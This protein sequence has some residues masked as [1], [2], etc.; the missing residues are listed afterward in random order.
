MVP[1]G[2]LLSNFTKILKM[3]KE[4]EHSPSEFHYPEDLETLNA[5]TETGSAFNCQKPSAI[6]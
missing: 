5:E 6:Q 4:D 1:F 3:D 2:V